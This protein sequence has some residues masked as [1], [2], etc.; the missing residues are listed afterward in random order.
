MEKISYYQKL[1]LSTKQELVYGM[2]RETFE[3]GSLI[4]KK[5]APAEKMFLI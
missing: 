3:V 1:S 5:D 2:E 4:C